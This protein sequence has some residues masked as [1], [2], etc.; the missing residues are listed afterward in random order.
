MKCPL[1]AD[2]WHCVV[3]ASTVSRFPS[4]SDAAS[5]CFDGFPYSSPNASNE[6]SGLSSE[7]F[8]WNRSSRLVKVANFRDTSRCRT[9]AAIEVVRSAPL[10]N[11]GNKYAL[12]RHFLKPSTHIIENDVNRRFHH[13]RCYILNDMSIAYTPI[14]GMSQEYTQAFLK[15]LHKFRN[16]HEVAELI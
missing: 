3:I 9:G 14:R 1:K 15:A 2:D 12:P 6:G 4:G 5:T 16:R 13:L 8:G 11:S 7:G 10:R